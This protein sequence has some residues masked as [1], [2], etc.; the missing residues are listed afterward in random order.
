M[1]PIGSRSGRHLMS[2]AANDPYYS[3]FSGTNAPYFETASIPGQWDMHV[4]NLDA[5]WSQFASAPI[6]AAPIAIVDTGVDVTHPDVM[7]PAGV[8]APKI[9]RAYC[10]VTYP[11]GTTQT[12]GPYVT[13]MDGH[14][15]NV[16]GIAD[17][18]TNNSFAFAGVAFDAPL[19]VYRIFPSTPAGGCEVKNPPAQCDTTSQDE[20]SAIDDAVAHGAKVINLSLGG[21]PPCSANDPE[22]VAVEHAIANGV[23]VVAAAGN[24]SNGQLDC[25]AADP[26]VI[27]VGASAINDTIPLSPSEYVAGY[28]NYLTTP[29]TSSGGAYLVAPGGDPCPGSF[30]SSCS[31]SDDLHWIENIYSSTASVQ[32]GDCGKDYAGESGDCR[33]LIAGTSMAVPHVS[34]VVSL[35]LAKNPSLTPAQIATGLCASSDDISDSKQGCGRVNASAAVMWAATH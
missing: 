14:G 33:I 3:G 19:L 20:S 7:T 31:D 24:E 12:S 2:I 4:I 13:D 17:A 25:P 8:T 23:V 11:A 1:L 29:G 30:S 10:Y 6:V 16:A 21:S 9:V 34:G 27:A 32:P 26:G 28:S 22:Y 5:A 18:D 35:M 15:T